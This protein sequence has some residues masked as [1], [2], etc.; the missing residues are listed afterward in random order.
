MIGIL[1]DKI[2]IG[3]IYIDDGNRTPRPPIVRG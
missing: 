1:L 3:F 2:S